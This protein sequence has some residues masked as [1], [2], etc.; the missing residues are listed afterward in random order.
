[1]KNNIA[2]L[3][4]LVFVLASG[5]NKNDPSENAARLRVKITGTTSS[6]STKFNINLLSVEINA[7]DSADRAA[8]NW[9][10]TEF[11]GGTYNLFEFSNGSSKQI[12]DEYASPK[13]VKQ[14]RLKFGS[15]NSIT[16]DTTINLTIPEEY[17]DGF[18]FDT[19]IKLQP[20]VIGSIMLDFDVLQSVFVKD[21][22]YYFLPHVRVYDETFG[23]KFKG[24]VTPAQMPSLVKIKLDND[25]VFSIPSN[26]S[27]LF[28]G[29]KPGIWKIHVIPD[30]LRLYKDTVFTDTIFDGKTTILN[31]PLR[32]VK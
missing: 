25:S 4:I 2:C 23:G 7:V 6:T 12:V 32:L 10:T 5:C 24:T 13:I 18:V 30:S 29:L 31:I 20:Y 9:M 27:F 22:N 17:K 21:N 16:S 19:D 15:D 3:L 14:V 26:G 28:S 11:K 1:M 8:D